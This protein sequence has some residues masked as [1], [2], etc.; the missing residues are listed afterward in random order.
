MIKIQLFKKQNEDRK[1][2]TKPYSKTADARRQPKTHPRRPGKAATIHLASRALRGVGSAWTILRLVLL[3]SSDEIVQ[4][5][6]QL[7]RGKR[8]PELVRK[9]LP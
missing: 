1:N 7:V 9:L 2:H 5:L 4:R 6:H 3:P 8:E